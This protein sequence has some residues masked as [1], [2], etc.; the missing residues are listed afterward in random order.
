[1]PVIDIH[2]VAIKTA[3]LDRTLDFYNNI[4]G[5][6]TVPR[7]PFGFPGAW[8]ALGQ[9]MF[10]IYAG[11]AAKNRDGIVEQ[12][13]GAV[14]HI[15]LQA[16]D[17]DEMKKILTR[18]NLSWRQNKV[19]SANL[20]QLFVRDPSDVII[21]LNFLVDHEPPGNKGPDDLNPYIPGQW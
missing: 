9:T 14:D 4:L 10:H 15:A 3:D 8:L 5:T 7:P 6:H 19:P 21:E 12:G 17:F 1:M 13:G 18:H 11:E 2:H 16:N 20:W